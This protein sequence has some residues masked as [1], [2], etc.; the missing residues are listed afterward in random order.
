[1]LS[2]WSFLVVI[3]WFCENIYLLSHV[4]STSQQRKTIKFTFKEYYE[5]I[6]PDLKLLW[7]WSNAVKL[8]QLLLFAWDV[9]IWDYESCDSAS[10]QMINQACNVQIN[11][12]FES[13]FFLLEFHRIIAVFTQPMNKHTP[14][15]THTHTDTHQMHIY[16]SHTHIN[17]HVH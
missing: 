17:T 10:L 14:T 7:Y 9:C 1:M 3:I 15:Y 16:C 12:S 2:Y 5:T 6:L 13:Y 4:L 8:I 11:L